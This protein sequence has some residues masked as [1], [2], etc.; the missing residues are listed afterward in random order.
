[1]GLLE[2]HAIPGVMLFGLSIVQQRDSKKEIV[3]ANRRNHDITPS[4]TEV[5][6]RTSSFSINVV[7]EE[8]TPV[9]DRGG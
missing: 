5:L 1:M 3:R 6:P 9:I 4:P 7:F 8:R 2:S